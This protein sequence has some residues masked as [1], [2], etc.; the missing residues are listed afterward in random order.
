MEG[1]HVSLIV[2]IAVVPI[3]GTVGAVLGYRLPIPAGVLVGTL[4]A[5]GVAG[6][7][8][9]LLGLP[10]LSVPPGTYSLLQI[11]LGMLVGFRMTGKSCGKAPTPCCPPPCS[12]PS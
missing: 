1:V 2:I 9:A 10:Q 12:R 5:V 11:M 4:V 3:F 6:G 7:G 8:A